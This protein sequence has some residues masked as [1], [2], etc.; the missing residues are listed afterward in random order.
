M[1]AGKEQLSCSAQLLGA[2]RFMM[3]NLDGHL[4]ITYEAV[5]HVK[6]GMLSQA[7]MTA[8]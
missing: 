8:A 5:P 4:A 3:L 1:L 7:S 2:Q 6:A